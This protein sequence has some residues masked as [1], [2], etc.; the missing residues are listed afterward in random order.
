MNQRI[1]ELADQ[2]GVY[3]TEFEQKFAEL[4]VVECAELLENQHTWVTNV[5]ASKLIREHFGVEND[6]H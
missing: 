2:S 5:A 4:I 3:L 1:K 6:A